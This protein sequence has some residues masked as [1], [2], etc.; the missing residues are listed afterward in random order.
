MNATTVNLYSWEYNR[1]KTYL[2]AAL[3]VAGNI[4]LPQLCHTVHLGGPTMLPI[5]FFHADRS[6]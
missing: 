6:L 3:F 2:A 4:L 1:T 5:Y